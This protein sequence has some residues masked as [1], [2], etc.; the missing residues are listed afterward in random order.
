MWS[1][2]YFG[3]SS[4]F[5][6]QDSLVW[7]GGEK[8]GDY[9]GFRLFC[10]EWCRFGTLMNLILVCLVGVEGSGQRLCEEFAGM[11]PV[12]LPLRSGCI[13]LG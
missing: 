13:A 6:D 2:H 8:V 5:I 9:S 1:A 4:V 10:W 3:L 12:W 7:S 11:R